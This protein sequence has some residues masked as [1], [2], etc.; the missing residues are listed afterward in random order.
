MEVTRYVK[1]APQLGV[2]RREVVDSGE[3]VAFWA[4]DK[5]VSGMDRHGVEWL[6]SEPTALTTLLADKGLMRIHR[7]VVLR[8]DCVVIVERKPWPTRDIVRTVYTVGGREYVASRRY[9]QPKNPSYMAP[10]QY[11][12]GV[13]VDP[14]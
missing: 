1:G 5:Y 9:S 14:V 4:D 11:K 12:D 10:G 3:F 6:L 2:S 13:K 8:R 7:G